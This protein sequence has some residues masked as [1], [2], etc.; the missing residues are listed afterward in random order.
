MLFVS[1]PLLSFSSVLLLS[2]TPSFLRLRALSGGVGSSS[3]ASPPLSPALPKYKLADYRY[4]REEMLALYVKD[5]KVEGTVA[6]CFSITSSVVIIVGSTDF[7]NLRSCLLFDFD[8]FYLCAVDS[9]RSTRQG[10]S[11]Y[12]ARGTPTAPS[13]RSIYRGGT[14]K[15]RLWNVIQKYYYNQTA[16][17]LVHVF[18]SYLHCWH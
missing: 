16:F 9:S 17:P 1:S 7:N 5:N 12:C 10:V 8:F 4:G 14:G 13:P 15:T 11:A 6:V 18:R 2:T 3:V